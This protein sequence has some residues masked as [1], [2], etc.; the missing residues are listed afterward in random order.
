MDPSV[1]LTPVHSVEGLTSIG[2]L[3]QRIGAAVAGLLG[4][5]ALLLS[6]LGVYGVVAF[7]VSQST[8]EIGIRMALG[9]GRRRVLGEILRRGVALALPGVLGGGALAALVAVG[10][11]RIDVLLGVAPADP[12]ALV[13]VA[14]LLT[15]VVLVASAIPATRASRVPPAEALR[16]E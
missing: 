14:G 13:S 3:P 7:L 4:A 6:G 2:V 5:V 9:A 11:S 10:L 16:H 15:G 1:S 8:R 12:L